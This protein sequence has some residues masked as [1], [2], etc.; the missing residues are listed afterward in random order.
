MLGT[1]LQ[2]FLLWLLVLW[3]APQQP[4][5]SGVHGRVVESHG[6]SPIHNAY[7]LAHRIGGTDSHV[8]TDENGKYAM[9]L[10]LGIYDVFI[11]ADG[12]SPTSRKV[13]VTPD[14]MMVYD[15]ALEFNMLGMQF[16]RKP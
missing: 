13:W 14:G 2:C 3:Q 4:L 1:A 10:P 9:E 11:S 16:D 5:P 12:H 7:V 6:H 8:S 15:A